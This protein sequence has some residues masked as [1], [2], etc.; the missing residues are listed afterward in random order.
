MALSNDLISQFVKITKDDKKVSNETTVY[1]TVVYDGKTYVRIDGAPDDVL[2]PISTTTNVKD[3][4]RVTIMIKDHTATIT[5][6][7][8]SPAVGSGE[9]NGVF[10]YSITE[11]DGTTTSVSID[12]LLEII[13]R[14]GGLDELDDAVDSLR[15]DFEVGKHLTQEQLDSIGNK[16]DNIKTTINGFSDEFTTEDLTALNAEITNLKGY[17]A[18]FTY[19]S[20]INAKF[21][22]LDVKFANIDFANIG[23]L[24]VR[25]IFAEA[26]I[27][28]E[29][30]TNSNYITGEL[31]GVTIKGD[32]IE[33]NTLKVNQLVMRGNDG[34]YYRVNTDFLSLKNEFVKTDEGVRAQDPTLVDGVF[35]T[36]GEQVY[37]A[38]L[39]GQTDENKV[40]ICYPSNP[41]PTGDE[42]PPEMPFLVKQ[43]DVVP[44]EEDQIHGSAMVA[45]SIT[46]EKMSVS[47][48]AAFEATIGGFHMVAPNSDENV[49]GALY[50]GSKG[51]VDSS[52]P[53][54]YLGQDGQVSI[55]DMSNYLRFRKVTQEDG[56]EVWK[57]EISADSILFGDGSKDN[58]DDIKKLTEHVKIGT[59][60]NPDDPSDENPSV[61]LSE[62]DSTFKQVITNKASRIMDGDNVITEMD[63]EGVES[64]NVSVRNELRQGEWTW[65][66]HGKGN[67]GLIWKTE[68]TD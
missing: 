22:N 30:T 64:K 49:V 10:T 27:I 52:I 59:W 26:G 31:V 7:V 35:T 11:N 56:S 18:E 42:P 20:A 57:L 54:I 50:S 40:Y 63:T 36:T 23:E 29:L 16:I 55:G 43:M 44:V 17:A 28:K 13:R 5:G 32:L 19:L 4:E 48:L 58:L 3:G 34:A 68:V 38:F 67:L 60:V 47:E 1:G 8:S 2:T 37:T 66:R 45:K 33:A 46:A 51:D 41:D 15:D 6:N 21:D 65:V 25:K 24:A 53:G 61:E 12:K 39:L 9:V 14:H 62:G